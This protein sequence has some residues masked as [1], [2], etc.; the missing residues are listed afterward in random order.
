M[1]FSIKNYLIGGGIFAVI[2]V[3][4][5]ILITS[6][7]TF[8]INYF[9]ETQIAGYEKHE[10][11]VEVYGSPNLKW[12][13]APA[14][15]KALGWICIP[16]IFVAA[17]VTDKFVGKLFTQLLIF[18]TPIVLCLVFWFA[19]YSA[20]LDMGKLSVSAKEFITVYKVNPALL[21]SVRTGATKNIP[22]ESGEITKY[23]KK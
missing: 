12:K 7:K 2:L 23:F 19:A 4:A 17:W 14:A 11:H 20:S 21:E 5:Q 15:T 6:D 8:E 18:A 22:D 1:K 9:G 13:E 10:A 3:V 16:L